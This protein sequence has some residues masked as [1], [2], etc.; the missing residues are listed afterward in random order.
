MDLKKLKEKVK[1]FKKLELERQ[2]A[3]EQALFERLFEFFGGVYTER[4]GLLDLFTLL[5]EIYSVRKVDLH[6]IV[7]EKE[8]FGIEASK[9]FVLNGNID[10]REAVGLSLKIAS[11]G[12]KVFLVCNHR[13]KG[14]L[15]RWELPKS[16]STLEELHSIYCSVGLGGLDREDREKILQAALSPGFDETELEE[17]AAFSKRMCF[18]IRDPY[19]AE[20]CPDF[21]GTVK[22]VVDAVD[23]MM[24]RIPYEARDR[25]SMKSDEVLLCFLTR[26]A[27]AVAAYRIF[28]KMKERGFAN[29]D[30]VNALFALFEKLMERCKETVKA[31][32]NAMNLFLQVESK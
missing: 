2:G 25:Y 22:S 3:T 32:E 15:W 4:K 11:E 14:D 29:W 10:I 8:G 24:D 21:D 19:I 16:V 26:A 17:V 30:A 28:K 7:Q 13:E 12:E 6:H 20:S 9:L 1:E 31:I 18:H 5:N 27:A 23:Y